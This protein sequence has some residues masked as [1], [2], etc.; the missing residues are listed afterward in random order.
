M[1]DLYITYSIRERFWTS[2]LADALESEG[3]TVWWDHPVTPGETVRPESQKALDEARCA[4]VVWSST[5]VEDHWVLV[6]SNAA[7]S[8]QLLVAVLAQDCSVP[9]TFQDIELSDLRDWKRGDL[10]DAHFKHL[11]KTVKAY[12]KPS[13]LSLSEKQK[14]A[15]ER[16]ERMRAESEY[17]RQQRERREA[18]MQT[19]RSLA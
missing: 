4:I 12:C 6:D 16:A 15:N 10:E 14:Q 2:Q 9:E 11:F 17:K 1:A 13:Q 7:K 8:R 3:Y 5:A 18:L 19:K